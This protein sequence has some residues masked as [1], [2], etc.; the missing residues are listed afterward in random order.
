VKIESN[1]FTISEQDLLKKYILVKPKKDEHFRAKDIIL[2]DRNK[3]ELKVAEI[4]G[5]NYLVRKHM[6]IINEPQTYRR[7]NA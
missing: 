3:K 1:I 5:A 6:D 2:I 7:K 4:S